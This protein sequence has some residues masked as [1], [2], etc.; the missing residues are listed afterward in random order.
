MQRLFALFFLAVFLLAGLGP[1]PVAE[2]QSAQRGIVVAQNE[3]GGFF[4]RLFRRQQPDERPPAVAPGLIPPPVIQ[5]Q[6]AEQ[7]RRQRQARPSSPKPQPQEVAAVEKA[8]DAKRAVVVGDFIGTALAKG[9]AETYRENPNVVIVNA[10][11][12]SSGL[13]RRDYYD[14]PGSIA[15]IVNEQKPDAIVVVLGANDRQGIA[16][17]SG[18]KAF[19]TDEWR[20]AY[21]ARVAAMADA[22]KSTGKPVLWAGL[23][24]V[25]PANMS[26]D[27]SAF[28]GIVREQL[29]AKGLRFVDVWNG[30]ADEDGKYVG[31]GPDVSGQVVLLRSD[32]GMNFTR[33]GLLKLAFFVEQELGPIFGGTAPQLLAT[34]GAEGEMALKIGPM[35]S[36][37]TLWL[38]GGDK[39]VRRSPEEDRGG[40]AIGIAA[41]LAE[42]QAELPPPSRA[43]SNVWPIPL[44]PP[45]IATV[46]LP[47]FGGPH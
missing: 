33:A 32:D 46:E 21:A 42:R 30:F 10:T 2:A 47:A 27:Y 7:P 34:A 38:E 20:T 29:E 8:P 17:E 43:D 18:D 15:G 19:G 5:R 45:P 28:N 16:T 4:K 11:S 22:L 40:I 23:V 44:P 1:G 9:L 3:P 24:P 39:L 41:H 14:W 25:A 26:R 12:G 31:A 36:L 35:V 37:D 6:P 13:V